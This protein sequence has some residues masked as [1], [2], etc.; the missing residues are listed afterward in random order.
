[1]NPDIDKEI[2]N[3]EQKALQNDATLY[4]DCMNN[5]TFKQRTTPQEIRV[6]DGLI[7]FHHVYM[8]IKKNQ[9]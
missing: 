1:M 6:R 3:Q 7:L 9:S 4:L 2:L 8:F 5:K